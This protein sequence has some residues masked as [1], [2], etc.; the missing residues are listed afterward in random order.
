MRAISV[1]P[2]ERANS[3]GV[4][5]SFDRML[6]FAPALIRISATSILFCQMASC[7]AV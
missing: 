6:R 5:P 1:R 3:S 4:W 2:L 7:S